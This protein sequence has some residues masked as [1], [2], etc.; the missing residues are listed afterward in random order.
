MTFGRSTVALAATVIVAGCASSPTAPREEMAAAE[1][2]VQ[3][4]QGTDADRYAP[5]DVRKAS[6]KLDEAE[7]A[8]R[9]EDYVK[10]RRLAEQALVDAQV[11]DVRADAAR[12]GEV[13]A[14]SE[15]SVEALEREAL[16]LSR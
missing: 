6:N 8:M 4:V 10:A 5:D 3:Q 15:E 1:L 16:E 12:S 13:L 11:A 7:T 14:Q 9:Q 2:A